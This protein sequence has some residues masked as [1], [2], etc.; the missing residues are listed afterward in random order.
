M[1]DFTYT[2][3]LW[4]KF[5]VLVVIVMAWNFWKGITGRK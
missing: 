2:D 4:L 1:E 5:G 3:W